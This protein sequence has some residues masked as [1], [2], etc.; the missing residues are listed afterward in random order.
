M[1]KIL[2]NEQH[3]GIELYFESRPESDT[4]AALKDNG[5]KWHSSKKCWYA[6]ETAERVALAES[7]KGVDGNS[8]TGKTESTNRAKATA[9]AKE[10]P[11]IKFYWNGFKMAGSDKLQKCFYS[12]YGESITIYAADYGASLPRDIF[13]VENE[14]DTMTDY[15]EKDHAIVT[16][17]HP[18]YK[19]IRFAAMAE[20]AHD[21]KRRI[22]WIEGRIAKGTRI[23]YTDDIARAKKQIA[24][25]EAM[26][27]PGDPT[28]ADLEAIRE[29][30]R[31]AQEEKEAA[32]RAEMEAHERHVEQVR[33]DGLKFIE[34]TRDAHPVNV[35]KKEPVIIIKWSEYPG[36]YAFDGDIVLSVTAAEIIINKFESDLIAYRREN[37][38]EIGYYK[39]EFVIK[40]YD[41]G[42]EEAST[43]TGRYDL[44]DQDGGIVEHIRA[45]GRYRAERGNFGN[46]KPSEEDKKEGEQI[47]AFADYLAGYDLSGTAKSSELVTV[48]FEVVKADKNGRIVCEY[49]DSKKKLLNVYKQES[50][51][52]ATTKREE[53]KGMPKLSGLL[54]P[55]WGGTKDGL[56]V[57][58]Y[59]SKRAYNLLSV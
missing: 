47:Q 36:F 53:L 44:G 8:T 38:K 1:C 52:T 29:N 39:T 58:R 21:V 27:N 40:Y 2:R 31:R 48:F 28:A 30:A 23:D 33:N 3:N 45:F 37:D 32:E 55:M 11:F 12:I 54:G 59:E 17:E 25:F 14:T 35:D 26:T 20:A 42:E 10:P 34:E 22:K 46:G 9:G 24:E 57:I 16:P 18:L 5:F 15:F 7:L 43:Y 6:I 19:Y 50:T 4:L 41:E 13:D 49:F 56:P 51:E